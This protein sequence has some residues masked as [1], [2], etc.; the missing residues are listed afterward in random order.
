MLQTY[1]IAEGAEPNVVRLVSYGAFTEEGLLFLDEFEQTL[2]SLSKNFSG[3]EEE[4]WQWLSNSMAQFRD[5]AAQLKLD[6]VVYLAS[7]LARVCDIRQGGC[8][9]LG[10]HTLYL[11]HAALSQL[12]FL[13]SPSK[14]GACENSLRIIST[15]MHDL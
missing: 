10:V 6:D 1:K 4:V 12:R 14:D 5:D 3:D 8:E 2:F 7:E 13:L 15:L 9:Q 11:V